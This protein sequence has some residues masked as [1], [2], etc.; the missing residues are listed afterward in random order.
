MNK[1]LTGFEK[2]EA[3][4][5]EKES[6]II[7]GLDPTEEMDKEIERFM[8]TPMDSYYKNLS[9]EERYLVGLE[10]YLKWLIDETAEHI[11]GIK[12]NM[13]FYESSAERKAVMQRVVEHAQS[14]NLI[15]ILDV[16]RGDIMDTQSEWAK[17]DITNF[18]PDI[19]TLNAYMGG[20]DVIQPYL[21]LDD[22]LC[23]YIL[24]ATSNPGAR[25]FQD[26][27]S[28]GIHNYQQ[29]ALLGRE[30]DS[31]RVGFVIGSTRPDAMKN[32][33][34]LELEYGYGD[35]LGHVLAPGFGKQGGNLE[36][37]SL[38]G[39]N[40]VY[41]ISS[42]LTKEQNLG[43]RTPKEAARDWRD[44]INTRI[45]DNNMKSITETVV[46]N[47]V[48]EDLIWVP[49][50]PE[51]WTWQL[52]KKGKNKL[53]DNNISMSGMDI[54]EKTALLKKALEDG[55]LD[56][57]DF[58]A[59]FLQLR[60]VIGTTETRRLLA[61]LYTKL[62][63]ESGVDFDRV[64]S[65]AYGAI[66]TGDLVSLF[67]DKPAFLLR[68]ERG[69]ETTHSDILG[70]LNENDRAIMIEDVTT[71]ADSLVKD[72]NMLRSATGAKIT[73]AF[74]FVKRTPEG[75]TNCLENGI[76]LHYV[77]DMDKLKIYLGK[78]EAITPEVKGM[79]L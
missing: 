25:K 63:N 20:A 76:K 65:I 14:K 49:K 26:Q 2:L 43:G 36:F 9:Y 11:V 44:E 10:G 27:V 55:V 13:A 29:M 64:G 38:S 52:L 70:Y 24:V 62:I 61:H 6:H 71:S 35:N 69:Q 68:K 33:R 56:S 7:L 51:I 39:P 28:G 32:V 1:K 8:P 74:V 15:T 59:I 48:N 22:S 53:T 58:G 72:V 47:M 12:P 45:N 4:I 21:D 78:S 34:S 42:G 19:V 66:N 3:Q 46:D 41:P 57:S 79:I 31:N 37:V 67:L 77:M 23:A 30:C 16:K 5:K 18:N 75:E 17:A 50:K 40:A 60:D 54:E 73:D